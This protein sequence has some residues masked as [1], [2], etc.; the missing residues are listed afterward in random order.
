MIAI[1]GI[2]RSHS[3][4]LSHCNFILSLEM[5][6]RI[7]LL[8]DI[9]IGQGNVCDENYLYKVKHIG[10]CGIVSWCMGGSKGFPMVSLQYHRVASSVTM[11]AKGVNAR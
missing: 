8:E 10:I 7:D 11:V 9:L 4:Y 3:T 5:K 6:A 2:I 1:F